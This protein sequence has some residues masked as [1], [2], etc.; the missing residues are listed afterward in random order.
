[1]N[2]EQSVYLDVLRIVAAVTVFVGHF[3]YF[4]SGNWEWALKLAHGSVVVF[5]V[6]SGFVI[7]HVTQAKERN[8]QIYAISRIAR[9][10]SVAL[11][12]LLLTI[13]LDG[14]SYTHGFSNDFIRP[15]QLQAWPKYAISSLLFL[16]EIWFRAETVFS[17]GPFWSLSY[18]VWYY[19]FFGILTIARGW[20]RWVGCIAVA[21]LVGP[22]L[23]ALFPVW[24]L[25]WLL[26][27]R[28]DA[29]TASSALARVIFLFSAVTI[30]VL[31]LGPWGDAIEE[32]LQLWSNGWWRDHLRYSRSFLFDY[33]IGIAVAANIWS[34]RYAKLGFEKIRG[35]A[36]LFSS[37]T[38]TLYLAHFP[39]LGF[40][41]NA[42]KGQRLAACLATLLCIAALGWLTEKQKTKIGDWMRRTV[43]PS[44]SPPVIHT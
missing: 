23:W 28:R 4:F 1:V 8:A 2:R 36:T 6:L 11:P 38:F 12:V 31:L 40:W 30:P 41:S 42:L 26:Y 44:R 34:V 7:T 43:G 9:I 29:W 25:G 32:Q 39:L 20:R 24:A 27:L 22:R 15:Y 3:H 16:T 33:L 37:F 19:V 13:A 18:E 35:F 14:W 5:F 21:M 17:N 10:Y